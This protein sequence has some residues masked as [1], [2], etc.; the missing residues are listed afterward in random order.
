MA[1]SVEVAALVGKTL[2]S[3]EGAEVGS[4][5]VTFAAADGS[6]Y[7]MYHD[8]DCCETVSLV[9]V[10]GD[11]A[12]LLGSPIAMAE[13]STNRDDLPPHTDSGTWTFYKFAT[14]KGYVTLRWLGES[15]GYYGEEVSFYE[16]T[17]VSRG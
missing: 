4:G 10:D 11:I 7:E 3:I 1:K 14:V 8:Q 9:N 6:R 5:R 13:E 17:E 12:D 2:V 15:N 16:T